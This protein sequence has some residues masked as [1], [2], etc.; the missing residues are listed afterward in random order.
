MRFGNVKRFKRILPSSVLYCTIA[1]SP[2]APHLWQCH[3]TLRLFSVRLKR[4]NILWRRTKYQPDSW[5]IDPNGLKHMH[6]MTAVTIHTIFKRC[7]SRVR[8]Q[9]SSCKCRRQD[10]KAQ[11]T[12]SLV[13]LNWWS[14]LRTSRQPIQFAQF[15]PF[16]SL[17][18]SCCSPSCHCK[19]D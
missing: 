1:R 17:L 13:G 7:L 9:N 11:A 2:S 8:I 14:V 12:L 5:W 16:P 6:Y 15:I 19:D 18:T 10:P 3:P 4:I